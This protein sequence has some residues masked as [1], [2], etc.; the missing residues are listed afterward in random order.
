MLIALAA[1]LA[2]GL[3]LYGSP[4]P[5]GGI[6]LDIVRIVG[7]LWLDA[8]SMTVVP[9]IFA[10]IVTGTM[11][12][13]RAGA[14]SAIAWRSLRWFAI[15]LTIACIMSAFA[16]SMLLSWW[17]VTPMTGT[18]AAPPDLS[19]VGWLEAIM[20]MNPVKAAAQSAVVP[21]VFFALLFGF[22][23][24]QI[25]ASSSGAILTFFS[26]V[27]ETMLVIVSWVLWVAPMGIFALAL[28]AG[29][30][31][32]LAAAG[33]LVQ[34]IIIVVTIC[35]LTTLLAYGAAVVAGGVSLRRFLRAAL[36]AQAVA[37][38]TQSSLASLPVM[39]RAAP[40]LEVASPTAGIVLPLAVSLFRAAS[41]AANVAVA[42]CLAHFHGVPL[43]WQILAIGTLV[44]IPVSLGAVGLPAQVSFFATIAP[45]CLAMGVP[46][47]AL[48]ILLAVESVPDVF[49]TVGNVTADLAVTRIVG[50]K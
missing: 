10:L 4:E 44:A 41:A 45:I 21:L 17:P 38:G 24:A 23:A 36:P 6:A 19:A 13:A 5:R 14:A 1:G 48:P 12:A 15:L 47:E 22:A 3:A 32:G 43:T 37:L 31:M 40:A 18:I 30:K 34:Y 42:I 50:S 2:A 7:Q 46:I 33:A 27:V 26:A 20:P 35:L 28:S 39:I 9:L 16:T 11:S 29:A 49:R 8:L 25:E